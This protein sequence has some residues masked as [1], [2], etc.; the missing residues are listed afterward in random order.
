MEIVKA[1]KEAMIT[2]E[3]YYGK[4]RYVIYVKKSKDE[5]ILVGAISERDTEYGLRTNHLYDLE[6]AIG[7]FNVIKLTSGMFYINDNNILEYFGN[8]VT[9]K[10]WKDK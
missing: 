7:G 4:E 9:Y 10:K 2:T 6:I 5:Y 3:H 1:Y 8:I